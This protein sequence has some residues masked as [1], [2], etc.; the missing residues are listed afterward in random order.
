LHLA[1]LS[2]EANNYSTRRLVEACK[3]R[4][5]KVRVLNTLNFSI[6]LEE[7]EPD[8]FYKQKRIA[9][10]DAVLPRV[11]ASLTYFGTAVVR[12]FQQMEVFS[13]NSADGILNSRDKLRSLQ[14]LSRH[15]IGIPPLSL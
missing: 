7:G 12:Q 4:N 6:D 2:K 3:Q 9:H 8:L 15:K 5:H 1:L 10:F 11:G 13:A 14:I